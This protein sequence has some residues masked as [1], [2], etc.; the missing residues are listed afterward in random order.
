MIPRYNG[1]FPMLQAVALSQFLYF[2]IYDVIKKLD[3][4]TLQVKTAAQNK[5]P[6]SAR[7]L[8]P[9]SLVAVWGCII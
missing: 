9:R 3:L 1:L 4:T 7:A 8:G 5:K 2:Y 6:R